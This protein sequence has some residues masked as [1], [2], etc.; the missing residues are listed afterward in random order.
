MD[1]THKL[2]YTKNKMANNGYSIVC[3]I[4]LHSEFLMQDF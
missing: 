4:L 2:N 3:A 1:E